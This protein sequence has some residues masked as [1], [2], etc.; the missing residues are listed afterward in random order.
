MECNPI[1]TIYVREKKKKKTKKIVL[2]LTSEAFWGHQAK[3]KGAIGSNQCDAADILRHSTSIH[4]KKKDHE[5]EST[6]CNQRYYKELK[7]LYFH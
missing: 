5:E 3:R 4:I 6:E 1:D 7:G 2:P